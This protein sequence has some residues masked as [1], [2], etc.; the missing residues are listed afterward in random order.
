MFPEAG[1]LGADRKRGFSS[2]RTWNGADNE[3]ACQFWD[4]GLSLTGA[5]CSRP[6]IDLTPI[7]TW[8]RQTPAESSFDICLQMFVCLISVCSCLSPQFKCVEL[9]W[10]QRGVRRAGIKVM[11]CWLLE[12]RWWQIL[13]S[14][15]WELQK[16][17]NHCS[18]LWGFASICLF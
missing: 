7:F 9:E 11:K 13:N 5:A 18:L 4:W 14:E 16:S 1:P 17:W 15:P 10:Q 8:A 2:V 3:T 12:I 6:N